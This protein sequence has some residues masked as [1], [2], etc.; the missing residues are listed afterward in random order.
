MT[1][2]A[3]E[4]AFQELKDDEVATLM[5]RA[6]LLEYPA[7]A[8]IIRNGDPQDRIL[9]ILEGEVRV[10]RLSGKGVEKELA[11]PL[12][13]G[14]TAGEMSFVDRMGASATLV[15]RSDV[16]LKAIDRETID[17]MAGKDPGFM[18]RF[19]HSLLI[20]VIRRLRVLDYKMT[21]ATPP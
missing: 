10:I 21:F 4:R 9:I 12:G 3:F 6:R 11:D 16:V 7:G 20:T 2:V 1:R 17:E 5:A 19:Y 13:P 14:D 15:S 8:V 18:T